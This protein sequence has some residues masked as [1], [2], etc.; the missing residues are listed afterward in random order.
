MS[1]L[2]INAAGEEKF[3]EGYE[4]GYKARDEEIVRCRDCK[5]GRL[6]PC[7][8][9]VTCFDENGCHYGVTRK[10][11]WYCADGKKE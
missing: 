5:F 10:A 7:A 6:H 2:I 3:D 11:D 4:A 9:F 8:E 1:E